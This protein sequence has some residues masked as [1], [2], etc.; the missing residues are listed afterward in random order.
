MSNLFPKTTGLPFVVWISVR[1][2]A[3]HDVRVRVA[4][5]PKAQ[6]N[7]MV[8]V[9]IRPEVR[10]VEGSMKPADLQLLSRW[11]E[12]NRETIVQYWNEE[13]DTSDVIAALR[14]V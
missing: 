7:D 14:P 13:I 5:G 2:N 10:V 9:A 12:L 8:S 11:I 3:G 4:P 1:G 6:A